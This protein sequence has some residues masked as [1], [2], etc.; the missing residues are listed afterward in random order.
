[1]PTV[2]VVGLGR[3][4]T[5]LVQ[6]LA[7]AK[8]EVIAVDG[9]E[10]AVAQ[11]KDFADEAVCADARDREVLERL[12]AHG[13]DCAVVAASRDV[14]RSALATMILKELGV[15]QVIARAGSPDHERLLRKLGADRVVIPLS[16]SAERLA[17]S[18][19][20]DAVLNFHLVGEDFA[21]VERAVTGN[22]AGK[23]LL[24][25][26]LRRRFGVTVIA[27]LH[28]NEQNPDAKPTTV[29]PDPA[30][31]LHEGEHFL[32]IGKTSDLEKFDK[33]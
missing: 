31:P 3:F 16:E 1:M 33:A 8:A 6:H 32:L 20:A 27:I 28:A 24:E 13:V 10:T 4:G 14:D 23:T 29:V 11:I 12:C 22:L 2:L 19:A 21:I 7:S 9:D 5:S 18:M 26:E 25:L 30:V 17:K 15:P